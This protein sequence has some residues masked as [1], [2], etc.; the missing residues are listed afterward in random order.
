MC[1]QYHIRGLRI[2]YSSRRI[3]LGHRNLLGNVIGHRLPH[4]RERKR[5]SSFPLGRAAVKYF[6]AFYRAIRRRAAQDVE[7]ESLACSKCSLRIEAKA[8]LH[9]VPISLNGINLSRHLKVFC[10]VIFRYLAVYEKN[11]FLVFD[12]F[13]Q[14]PASSY[15]SS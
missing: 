7:R 11:L 6:L 12:S 2:D 15:S 8:I 9:I 3:P 1:P 13:C 5:L 4:W 10:K 14:D